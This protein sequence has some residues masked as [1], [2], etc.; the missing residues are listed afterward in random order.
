MS[1]SV[2]DGVFVEGC[3]DQMTEASRARSEFGAFNLH[4]RTQLL[5]RRTAEGPG[6]KPQMIHGVSV[7]LVALVA[8]RL[9]RVSMPVQGTA[10]PMYI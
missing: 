9:V 1:A 5:R 6:T 7:S 2:T 10:V 4:P 3:E 8:P